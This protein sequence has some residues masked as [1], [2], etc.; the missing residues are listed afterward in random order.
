MEQINVRYGS[1]LDF[2]IEADEIGAAS[3]TFYV[4]RAGEEP[5]IT[6]EAQFVDGVAEVTVPAEATRVPLGR[7]LYQ[8]TVVYEDGQV[9]KYPRAEDCIGEDGPGLPRFNVLEALDETEVE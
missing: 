9:E 4:G 2:R 3:A 7:Y 6:A 1:S 8:L 5:V